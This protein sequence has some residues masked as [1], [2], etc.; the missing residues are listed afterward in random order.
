M[1]WL[2]QLDA[3]CVAKITV[4]AV[5]LVVLYQVLVLYKMSMSAPER[6]HAL[7]YSAGANLRTKTELSATNQMPYETGYNSQILQALPLPGVSQAQLQANIRNEH[8]STSPKQALSQEEILAGQL[9]K[10]SFT[11]PD[12]EVGNELVA[13]KGYSA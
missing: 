13:S 6:F 12:M 5:L 1:D 4:L 7:S 9:Y 10:E 2:N 3:H 11:S 8:M